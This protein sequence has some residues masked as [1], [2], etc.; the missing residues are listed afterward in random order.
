MSWRIWTL[1]RKELRSLFATPI[2]YA[3]LTASVSVTAV[4]FFGSLL[5]FNQMLFV[6]HGYGIGAGGFDSGT[7]PRQLN[8][9]EE[10]FIPLSQDVS[11]MLM[12]VVPVITMRVFAEEKAQGTDEL[13]LTTPLR[14][15]EIAAAKYLATWGF[16]A[17]LLA[18]SALYPAVAAQQ[19]NLGVP[20]LLA[21]YLGELGFGIAVASIG[22]A[23]S[24][25]SRNQIVAAVVAYALSFILYDFQWLATL[26]SESFARVLEEVEL[27]SHLEAFARGVVGLRHGVYFL[28]V[29][30][31]GFTIS[32]G[33]I[34]L[35]RA[36]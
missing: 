31:V 6:F 27:Q 28:G 18:V 30:A 33:S 10:V 14:S 2:A 16:V 3:V 35:G 17:L 5:R 15:W 32:V 29:G 25:L 20:H 36:R 12:L 4:L 26:V 19:A 1:L 11:L 34:E 23:C 22:L 7:T 9:L 8:L 13:L 21:L 24:S